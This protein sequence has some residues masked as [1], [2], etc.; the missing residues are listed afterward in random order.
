MDPVTFGHPMTKDPEFPRCQGEEVEGAMLMELEHDLAL[1]VLITSSA[2]MV[3]EW[4]MAN[5]FF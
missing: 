5:V 2:M 1:L 3:R 4:K